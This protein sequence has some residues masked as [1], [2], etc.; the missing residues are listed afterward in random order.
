MNAFGRD[1]GWEW[2]DST[3]KMIT[4]KEHYCFEFERTDSLL[5]DRTFFESPMACRSNPLYAKDA[6][7]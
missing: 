5:K 6:D 7:L 2:V 1:T 3:G 4:N